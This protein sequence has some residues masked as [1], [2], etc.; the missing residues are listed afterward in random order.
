MSDIDR[1]L[2]VVLFALISVII[3]SSSLMA[4]EIPREVWDNIDS[5]GQVGIIVNL[6]NFDQSVALDKNQR[7]FLAAAQ[8]E[9]IASI[10][11]FG[12]ETG[13]QYSHLPAIT[14]KANADVLNE[15]ATRTDI[16]SIE[17]DLPILINLAES[18]P[19]LGGDY[20]HNTLGFNGS[21]VVVAVFDTGI[22]TDHP[23]FAGGRI[24]AQ[25]HFL[26]QGTDVGPGAEDGNGHGTHCSGIIGGSGAVGAPG[27][28]PACQFVAVKVLAD[29][30]TGWV[31]DWGAALNWI[32]AGSNPYNISVISASL[33]TNAVYGADCSSYFTSV[34]QAIATLR[35][36]GIPMVV[37]SGN[38]GDIDAMT[39]PACIIDVISVGAS[40]DA[41]LGREPDGG[42]WNSVFGG[43]WPYC[44]DD[45]ALPKNITCFTSRLNILDYL[46]PGR[47]ISS[48]VPGGGTGVYTG[49]SMAAPHVAGLI[50]L[51]KEADPTIDVTGIES[52]LTAT[53][54]D[55]YDPASGLTFK[56]VNAQQAVLS[57]DSDNDGY[58]GPADNCPSDYNPGQ[59]DTDLDG[60]GD[61][62][63][64]IDMRGNANGDP[65]DKV[66]IS[67]LTYLVDYLFGIPAGTAPPCP[68]E[69][70][71]NGDP[72]EKT[73]ITDVTYLVA[74]LF[75]VPAGPAPPVCP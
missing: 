31:S 9:L 38:T 33:G 21:G 4:V 65:E 17:Y 30:G 18:V 16:L 62:C 42:T 44:Y 73:T 75:G 15:L 27:M 34:A 43:T 60:I 36:W 66:N 70:N 74:H 68:A 14:G 72:E 50:A 11:Q 51:M 39:S 69:G 54:E 12:F 63:C 71:A 53:G 49:T 41:S 56:H 22:D 47:R 7:T 5:N 13:Y 64:C 52:V 35:L 29:D 24:I 55:I 6:D 8:D 45:P 32:I 40:F 20:V 28:A 59:E 48:S 26:D 61:A 25:Q 3:F 10:E 23:N 58:Y 19:L 57:M 37:S 67:D 2:P 46:A 1:H